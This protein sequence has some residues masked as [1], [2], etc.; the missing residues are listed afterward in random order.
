MA[1]TPPMSNPTRVLLVDD[2]AAVREGLKALFDLV[3]DVSIAA[4]ASSAADALDQLERERF[5]LM[6]VDLVLKNGPDGVQ[7]T[8]ACVASH[9]HVRVLMLSGHEESL[10]AERAVAAGALGYIMKDEPFATLLEAVKAVRQGRVWLSADIRD[11]LVPRVRS[12]DGNAIQARIV[13]AIASG[14]RSTQEL[15]TRCDTSALQ[16]ELALQMLQE[17]LGVSS[18]AGLVLWV[19]SGGRVDLPE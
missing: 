14:A 1:D 7:L 11:Q 4:E 5:D 13:E 18:R 10:F 3:P 19:D 12:I 15:S 16:V 6:L 17:R 2:H 9:P 8:K